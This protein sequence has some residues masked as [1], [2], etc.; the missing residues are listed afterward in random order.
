MSKKINMKVNYEG[1]NINQ[2]T[3]IISEKNRLL[4]QRTKIN[5]IENDLNKIHFNI[6]GNGTALF[7]AIVKYNLK[8]DKK[9][10]TNK[11]DFEFSLFSSKSRYGSQCEYAQLK[12]FSKYIGGNEKTGMSIV[13]IKLPSGWT[14]IE[15]SIESL[16]EMVDLKRYEISNENRIFLYF[17]E[18]PKQDGLEFVIHVN[19]KFEIGNRKPG[20]VSVYD[21]YADFDE[22]VSSPFEIDDDCKKI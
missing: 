19:K 1:E 22:S 10:E 21:Y 11:P 20:L 14:P 13:S 8:E 15:E 7:Q 9:H 6:E 12:I 17:N 18:I 5:L 3:L 16:K 4:I 2:T